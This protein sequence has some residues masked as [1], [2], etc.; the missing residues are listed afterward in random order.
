MMDFQVAALGAK[1]NDELHS[2]TSSARP[3]GDGT[4]VSPICLAGGDRLPDRLHF[5]EI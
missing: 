2:I 3:S 5:R 1:R 4:M